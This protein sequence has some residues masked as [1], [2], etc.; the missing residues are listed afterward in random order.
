VVKRKGRSFS[1]RQHWNQT[2]VHLILGG[3]ALMIVVGG[4][5]VGLFYGRTSAITAISCLLGVGAIIGL[6][7][8]LLTL[9]ERWLKED[10]P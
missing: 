5:L 6:I 4:G 3:M 1:P 10:K 7:W 2:Q 8:L 9:L